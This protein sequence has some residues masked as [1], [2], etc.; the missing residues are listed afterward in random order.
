MQNGIRNLCTLEGLSLPELLY[1]TA[2]ESWQDNVFG[3]GGLMAFYQFLAIIPSL[4]AFL[5]LSARIP[6]L[7]DHMNHTLREL[8]SQVLPDQV[9]Q[10]FQKTM[11]GLDE[12]NLSVAQL[13]SLCAGALWA[14]LN[15]TWAMVYGLN[16]AYE[17]QENRPWGELGLTIAG[18]T[19]SLALTGSLAIFMTFGGALLQARLH[20]GAIGLRVSEW[21]ILIPSLAVS[22]TVLYRFA[23]N[24]RDHKWR[25][26][27][28][29]ALCAVVLWIASI[30]A[31][32][33][34]F[35][36]IN[37]YASSYGSLNGVVVFLLWLYVTNGAILIGGEMNSEIEKAVVAR[38]AHSGDRP[39]GERPE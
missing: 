31:A 5:A 12:R 19:L 18:L 28:P 39:T 13:V 9:S 2:R 1:R 24:V 3:Q 33:I 16:S 36:H 30:S 8:G 23:P 32:R 10:L 29:G 17:V 21:L 7:G 25:W 27:T 26:S 14:A 38:R 35:N 20:W 6:N 22:F 11:E 37:S 4:L 15:G 34:Y